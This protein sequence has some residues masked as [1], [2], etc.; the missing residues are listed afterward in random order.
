MKRSELERLQAAWRNGV[1][2]EVSA[3][4]LDGSIDGRELY[5]TVQELIDVYRTVLLAQPPLPKPDYRLL[6]LTAGMLGIPDRFAEDSQAQRLFWFLSREA[7][8]KWSDAPPTPEPTTE[9]LRY[10]VK[11]LRELGAELGVA[12]HE[13]AVYLTAAWLEGLAEERDHG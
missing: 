7:G 9:D 6:A 5:T 2:P 3:L 1:V 4:E 10:G 11:K 8:M 12:E 13:H